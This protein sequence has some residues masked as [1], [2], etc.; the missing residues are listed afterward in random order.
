MEIKSINT[1]VMNLK[2][3]TDR[4][5]H[6]TQEFYGRKEFNLKIVT[7]CENKVGAM[8]LWETLRHIIL[9]LTHPDDEFIL[10]CE[11]DHQFTE[12]YSKE[13]LWTAIDEAKRKETD[14]L[15]GG[16]SWYESALRISSDLF[17][18]DKFSG[19]QFTIIYR[20]FFQTILNIDF[21]EIDAADY[22]ISSMSK[23]KLVMYPFISVQKEFGYSDVTAK[24]NKSGYVTQLFSDSSEKL[25]HLKRVSEFYNVINH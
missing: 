17:W 10:I 5:E 7:A 12:Y 9:T 15:L 13:L 8:G 24:N 4:Y 18:V 11:D 25:D 21:G 22:K 3:R 16:L 20:K 2:H 14:I 19:L 6:I 1:Y 23:N